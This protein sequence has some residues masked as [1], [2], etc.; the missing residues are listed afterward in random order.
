MRNSACR[1][2]HFGAPIRNLSL[3][4]DLILNLILLLFLSACSSGPADVR[5]DTAPDIA[6]VAQADPV[7]A[8]DVPVEAAEVAADVPVGAG[9]TIVPGTGI[10]S[11]AASV[12]LGDPRSTVVA[13]LGA[14]GSVRDL[15]APGVLLSFPSLDLSCLVA[16]TGADAP[17]V[18]LYLAVGF[19]GQTAGGVR[20]GLGTTGE[21]VVR[22]EF[23][24][25]VLDPFLGTWRYPAQGIAVDWFEDRLTSVTVSGAA[26]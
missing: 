12:R 22:D 17:I 7:G 16:G 14:A 5:K 9:F 11:A 18:A 13:A 8:G 23:G 3:I 24:A 1:Q 6:D 10:T 4:P 21:Q 19:D 2:S 26:P 20:T 25:P 15:G